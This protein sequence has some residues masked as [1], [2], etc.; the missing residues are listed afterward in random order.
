MTHPLTAVAVLVAA[1]TFFWYRTSSFPALL[2]TLKPEKRVTKGM[3]EVDGDEAPPFVGELYTLRRRAG[4][5]EHT[6]LRPGV[7]RALEFV[8]RENAVRDKGATRTIEACVEDFFSRFDAALLG[9][10][11]LAARSVQV[12]IDTR[13]EA[14]AAFGALLSHARPAALTGPLRA[15]E[16][17]VRLETQRCL[18]ILGNKHAADPAFVGAADWRP[19][20]PNF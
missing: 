15:A 7:V 18:M 17:V 13:A 3:Q 16:R 12:L 5:M 10:A 19:P 9:P 2:D 4:A 14:L 11:D 6:S 8:R 1:F 20:Y